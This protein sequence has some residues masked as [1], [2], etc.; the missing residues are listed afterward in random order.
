MLWSPQLYELIIALDMHT[1]YY[2][3]GEG[4]VFTNIISKYFHFFA[5]VAMQRNKSKVTPTREKTSFIK[6]PKTDF[7][8]TRAQA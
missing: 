1:T 4:V 8:R 2:L 3:I 7:I 6:F 5:V